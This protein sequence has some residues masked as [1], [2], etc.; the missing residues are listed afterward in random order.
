[1]QIQ[2]PIGG[3]CCRPTNSIDG[4]SAEQRPR[5]SARTKRAPVAALEAGIEEERHKLSSRATLLSIAVD[6]K[7]RHLLFTILQSGDKPAWL[8]PPACPGLLRIVGIAILGWQNL[9]L[10]GATAV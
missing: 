7:I 2:M 8:Q 5:H 3:R 10:G 4:L 6:G 1:M 9:A